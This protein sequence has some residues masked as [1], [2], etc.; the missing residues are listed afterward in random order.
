MQSFTSIIFKAAL[1]IAIM[2][3]GV[4]GAQAAPL[5]SNLDAAWSFDETSG[6]FQ[7]ATANNNDATAVSNP[8]GDGSNGVIGGAMDL[9]GSTDGANGGNIGLYNQTDAFSVAFWL[10]LNSPASTFINFIGR[11]DNSGGHNEGWSVRSGPSTQRQKL[12]FQY[13]G[14]DGSNTYSDAIHSN[15]NVLGTTDWLFIVLTH[16]GSTSLSD[17]KFYVNGSEIATSFSGVNQDVNGNDHTA[18]ATDFHIGQRFDTNAGFVPGLMDEAALWSR[19]LTAIEISWL[20]NGGAGQSAATIAATAATV[21]EPATL[22]L[23]MLGFGAL[24][25]RRSDRAGRRH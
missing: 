20:W 14:Y 1:A 6:D 17:T 15:T 3:I 16:N 22:G 10:K 18:D 7:D 21:P 25:L 23:T 2:F 11:E 5:N 13:I 12:R 9:D 24:V 4:A 8:Y 19:E